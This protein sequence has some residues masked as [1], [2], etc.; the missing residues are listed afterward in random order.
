MHYKPEEPIIS[1]LSA[2]VAVVALGFATF[3]AQPGLAGGG[4]ENVFLL[5]NSAS[6]DSLTVANHYV[7]LREIPASNILFLEWDKQKGE[8]PGASFRDEIL[9]PALE[10]IDRRGLQGQ[11]DYLIYSCDFPWK[12][13]FRSDFPKEK[14]TAGYQPQGSITGATYLWAFVKDKRKEMF[15]INSNNYYSMPLNGVTVSR[16]FRAQVRWLPGGQRADGRGIPYLLSAM[17]GVTYGRGNRVDEI[18]QYLQRAREADGTRPSGTVYF[19]KHDGVRSRTRDGLFSQAVAEL[20]LAGV[21]AEILPFKF[22]KGKQNIAGLTTG[23]P[24]FNLQQAGCRML[25]GSIGDNLTSFGGVFTEN[26]SQTCLSEFLRH[27]AAGACGTV[28]EPLSYPQKFPSPFVH[29]HYAH[30]CSLAEAFY[31]SIHAPFQQIIVGDPLCQP[32]AQSPEVRVAGLDGRHF[33]SG[34]LQLIPSLPPEDARPIRAFE[35]F[36]DGVRYKRCRQGEQ[37]DLDTAQFA[38]GYHEL[39]VVATEDTPIETQGRWLGS[40][41]VKNGHDAIQL[42]IDNQDQLATADYVLVKVAST[43]KEPASIMGHGRKL[44]EVPSGNGTARIAVDQ[45]G[46]GPVTLQA[47]VAGERGLVSRPL[48]IE[49]P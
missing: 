1:P 18:I 30:G 34:N 33:T 35:L 24:D 44:A 40:V 2:I 29:V 3:L 21:K 20:G 37:F 32:W 10:E 38:D 4:P 27:G 23:V 46:S 9:L 47:I 14:F 17:L 16:A 39:R 5:V 15:G 8:I 26:F 48:S 41:M 25:P 13:D 28:V 6:K 7:K 11:I 31:Q 49:I 19:L 45:L 42:S 43:Q 22:P 12:V 36:V